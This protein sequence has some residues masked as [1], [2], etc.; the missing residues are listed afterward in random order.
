[1]VRQRLRMDGVTPRNI[2][3]L[4]KS[5]R[6]KGE[7]QHT[8]RK[9]ALDIQPP[10]IDLIAPA[11]T[12]YPIQDRP[13]TSQWNHRLTSRSTENISIALLNHLD[14]RRINP[15]PDK[16]AGSSHAPSK[17]GSMR[18][19]RSPR[20]TNRNNASSL[21]TVEECVAHQ[22]FFRNSLMFQEYKNRVKRGRTHAGQCRRT[23]RGSRRRNGR[24]GWRTKPRGKR[25][26]QTECVR[27]NDIADRR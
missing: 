4:N 2:I 1:M 7:I 3:E 27:Q 19:S 15:K 17:A 23:L 20:S 6:L 10:R 21:I 14:G 12:G 18:R 8:S 24:R 26:K 13:H 9:A 16:D 22:T 25:R 5:A 11:H